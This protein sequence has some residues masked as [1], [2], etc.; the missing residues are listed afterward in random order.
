MFQFEIKAQP[1]PQGPQRHRS[2]MIN[3]KINRPS[4][5]DNAVSSVP[6]V[7][8]M[9]GYYLL[10]GAIHELAHVM[11]TVLV[12][13]F[14]IQDNTDDTS[15]PLDTSISPATSSPLAATFHGH[16]TSFDFLYSITFGR[17]FCPPESVLDNWDDG[18]AINSFTII[19]HSGW[20]VSVLVALLLQLYYYSHCN[21]TATSTKILNTKLVLHVAWITA[22]EAI[23]TDLLGY[24]EFLPLLLSYNSI[25]FSYDNPCSNRNDRTAMLLCGNF[26]V[27][28]LNHMW[29]S[30]DSN[31]RNRA[32]CRC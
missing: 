21:K 5:E 9:W 30:S 10:F 15:S 28:V 17:N 13:S 6:L 19:Q 27:I 20:I 18:A 11:A 4:K 16:N 7:V 12:V 3:N 32:T 2:P 24:G 31:R 22:M 25:S 8:R 29:L 1:R 23:F 14:S 26:G